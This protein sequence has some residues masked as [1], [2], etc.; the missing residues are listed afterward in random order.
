MR[1][2]ASPELK[3]LLARQGVARDALFPSPGERRPGNPEGASAGLKNSRA[4][5]PA[6]PPSLHSR[7]RGFE[8]F[9]ALCQ[10]LAKEKATIDG[11]GEAFRRRYRGGSRHLEPP[12][13]ETDVFYRT[14]IWRDAEELERK[15][16]ERRG[17]GRR[18]GTIG[19]VGLELMRSIL[20]RL[21]KSD[22]GKVYPSYETLAELTQYCQRA[23]IY[24][25]KRLEQFGF[26]TIH[27][28]CKWI[29]TPYGRRLVQD[30]N[31]YEYH[32]PKTGIGK[33]AMAMLTSQS[34][35]CTGS[36]GVETPGSTNNAKEKVAPEERWWLVEP[37][38]LGDG[39][40]I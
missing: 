9:D 31:A 32:R 39:G 11:T 23:I 15:S 13:N 38:P 5:P 12:S 24:A 10:D 17:K 35:D 8:R 34:S 6:K 22:A 16:Y 1:L 33:L 36:R 29:E 3:A 14:M 21:D 19:K 30:S 37:I 20:F 25:M 28:R 27:R 4:R 7:K 40:W 2:T 18:N 26:V